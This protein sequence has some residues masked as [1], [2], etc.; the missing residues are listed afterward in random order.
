METNENILRLLEM[1]DNPDAYSEQEIREIINHDDDTREAYRIMVATKQGFRMKKKE[2]NMSIPNFTLHSPLRKV[3]ASFIGMLFVSAFTLAA[4]HFARQIHKPTT[5][6]K[7]ENIIS[8]NAVNINPTDSIDAD[9]TITL[10]IVFDNIPL[11]KMLIEISVYYKVDIKY[12]NED[13]RKLRFH[14]V[15]NPEQGIE[16]VVDNLNHFERLHVTWKEN[17]IIVE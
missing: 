10:P 9:T 13:A 4:I 11:E 15:W 1:L 12:I 16:K 2:K 17:Q 14:F 7:E 3:A 6:Q 5:P 8:G